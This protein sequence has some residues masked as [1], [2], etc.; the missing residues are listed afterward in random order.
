MIK[1]KKVERTYTQ[2]EVAEVICDLC[3]E[4]FRDM[5]WDVG[6]YQ[7]QT[8]EV[9]YEYGTDYP[10]DRATTTLEFHICPNCFKNKLIPWMESQGATPTKKDSW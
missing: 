6:P 9:S 3:K 8:T 4:T 2:D 10:G 7:V 1:L 5:D